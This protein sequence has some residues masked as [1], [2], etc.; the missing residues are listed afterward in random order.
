[1]EIFRE[2][3]SNERRELVK[4]PEISHPFI[5]ESGPWHSHG[6]PGRDAPAFENAK[7]RDLGVMIAARSSHFISGLPYDHRST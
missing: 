6:G 3:A 7:L 1:M 5:V 4:Y 2:R